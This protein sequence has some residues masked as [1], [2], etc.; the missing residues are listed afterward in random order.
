MGPLKSKPKKEKS[1]ASAGSALGD[2]EYLRMVKR[3]RERDAQK[4]EKESQMRGKAYK[5]LN[6]K[7]ERRRKRSLGATQSP[8]RAI[9]AADILA[10]HANTEPS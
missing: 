3:R 1:A 2:E 4:H 6:A 8:A 5:E 9:G 10:A 7:T